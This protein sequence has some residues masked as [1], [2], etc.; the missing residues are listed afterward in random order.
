MR[1]L[2]AGG[3]GFI[4][5]HLCERLLADGNEVTCLDNLC[6]GNLDNLAAFNS[7]PGFEFIEGDVCDPID[8]EVEA[9]AH[10]ASPASPVDYSALPLETMAANSQGTFQLL[11]LARRRG[12]RFLFASTSE[13][14]GDPQVSPQGED[15]FGNVNPVGI[16]SCYD[17][18][19]RFGEALT[20]TYIRRH[21]INASIVRI[22][23][24]FGPRMRREDGRAVPNF[25]N[26]ALAG[27]PLTIYGD[28]AQTRSFCYVDDLVEGLVRMLYRQD[29]G[30]EIINLGT[31]EEMTILALAEKVKELTGSGSGFAFASLPEDDPLVRRPDLTKARNVLGWEARVSLAEGLGKVVDWFAQVPGARR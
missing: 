20:F 25:I 31:D 24:T 2:V 15:Y 1:Y 5:S 21:G 9:I 26:Q 11:E 28:G 27:E 18:S 17:E 22:F 4:G 14:Y 3:A 16:R 29:L 12:A 13:V 6:T 8:L 23:N 19:K 10:F 7:H 30:G